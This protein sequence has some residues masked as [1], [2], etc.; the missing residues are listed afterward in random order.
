MNLTA[1]QAQVYAIVVAEPMNATR[2][3]QRACLSGYRAGELLRMLRDLG[4]LATSSHGK[5]AV[6][7]TPERAA[8]MREELALRQAA[9]EKRPPRNRIEPMPDEPVRVIRAPGSWESPE[10]AAGQEASVF[11]WRPTP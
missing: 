4:L 9:G 1:R 2:V 8:V 11:N 3:A 6:W 7:T 5:G 10:R